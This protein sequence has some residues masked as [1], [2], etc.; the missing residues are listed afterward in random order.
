L[1]KWVVEI[2]SKCS[3]SNR[4]KPPSVPTHKYPSVACATPVTLLS[5]KP[6]SVC[7]VSVTHRLVAAPLATPSIT[8]PDRATPLVSHHSAHTP[9]QNNFNQVD[10]RLIYFLSRPAQ[11]R[12]HPDSPQLPLS[13]FTSQV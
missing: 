7:Q 12:T 13:K 3:P 5:G 10:T 1:G 4:I 11:A 6:S 9:A 2:S 8:L